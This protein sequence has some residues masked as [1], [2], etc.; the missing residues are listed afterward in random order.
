M[1]RCWYG[2]LIIGL[3]LGGA[4]G[5]GDE[6]SLLLV[7]CGRVSWKYEFCFGLF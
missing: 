3:F 6:V 4:S 1:G 2:W 5:S 7:V